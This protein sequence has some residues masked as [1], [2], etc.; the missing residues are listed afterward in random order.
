MPLDGDLTITGD[1]A[2]DL[3]AS[4]SG[5]DWDFIV[6]LIDVYPENPAEGVERG[7]PPEGR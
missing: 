1:V 3:F 4:P 5:T 6:K 7:G 2:G